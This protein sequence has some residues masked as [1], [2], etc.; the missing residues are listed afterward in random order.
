MLQGEWLKNVEECHDS[1]SNS[2]K[3]SMPS[4]FTLEQQRLKFEAQE[5]NFIGICF[6]EMG[7]ILSKFMN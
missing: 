3:S 1:K 7:L 5:P 6:V 4:P 2:N